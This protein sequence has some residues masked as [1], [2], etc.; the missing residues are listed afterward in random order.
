MN[1]NMVTTYD[2]YKKNIQ[3]LKEVLF[4][5]KKYTSVKV[6]RRIDPWFFLVSLSLSMYVKEGR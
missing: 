2:W 6:P 4:Y 5:L 1:R 3:E